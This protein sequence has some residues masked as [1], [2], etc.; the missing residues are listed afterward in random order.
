[1]RLARSYLGC[2]SNAH[3]AHES[4]VERQKDHGLARR[5]ELLL[6]GLYVGRNVDL[7]LRQPRVRADEHPLR[8][9]HTRE[10]HARHGLKL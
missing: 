9:H 1:M 7:V 6:L 3:Q 4:L 5:L 2:I 10:T 8:A